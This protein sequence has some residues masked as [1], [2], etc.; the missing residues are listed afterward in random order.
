MQ[1]QRYKASK[2]AKAPSPNLGGWRGSPASLQTL[3]DNR[4]NIAKARRCER[5]GRQPALSTS[6]FCLKHA[7][8]GASVVQGS[9]GRVARRELARL[10][11]RGLI[12][13]G[14]AALDVFR[15]TAFGRVRTCPYGLAL[16]HAWDNRDNEPGAWVEAVR[17]ARLALA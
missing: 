2:P 12:P 5:C 6:R 11:R 15:A 14:L 4:W 3:A 17:Q 1:G 9:P 10:R 16:V 13:P 8:R 7:G